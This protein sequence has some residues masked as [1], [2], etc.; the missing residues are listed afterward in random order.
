M[1]LHDL[2]LI[3]NGEIYNFRELRAELERHGYAFHSHSDTEVA[4][5][6]LHL[7]GNRC[8]RPVQRYVRAGAGRQAS[9]ARA[10]CA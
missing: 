9:Q 3:L 6:A 10:A 8:S 7:W 1:R 2:T 4:L 5:A